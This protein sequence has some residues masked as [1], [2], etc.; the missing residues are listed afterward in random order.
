MSYYTF[1]WF[2]FDDSDRAAG[3][4]SDAQILAA[5]RAHLER[6]DWPRDALSALQRGLEND[7]HVDEGFV[8]L[9]NV[10]IIDLFRAVSAAFPGLRIFARGLGE[11]HADIWAA[12]LADGEIV[13]QHGPFED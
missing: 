9:R 1:T 3:Q 2:S 4:P 10:E 13:R 6:S 7:G 5:A 12:E 8:D 11:E